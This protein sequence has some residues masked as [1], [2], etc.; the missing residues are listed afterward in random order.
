MTHELHTNLLRCEHCGQHNKLLNFCSACHR[1]RTRIIVAQPH[2][3]RSNVPSKWRCK[4]C[5]SQSDSSGHCSYC[6][7]GMVR[8]DAAPFVDPMDG[9]P[10]KKTDHNAPTPSK[11]NIIFKRD[12]GC[13]RCETTSD[14][15]LHHVIHTSQGG[16]NRSGNLQTLCEPCHAYLHNVLGLPSGTPYSLEADPN[17]PEL[18]Q[19]QEDAQWN[20]L[21]RKRFNKHGKKPHTYDYGKQLSTNLAAPMIKRLREEAKRPPSA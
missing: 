5:S 19:E 9:A 7:R 21:R 18:T 8:N 16:S 17:P 15:T 12:G 10:V 11:R 14:L 2:E 3:Y 6:D 1:P 13:L 20:L 4:R